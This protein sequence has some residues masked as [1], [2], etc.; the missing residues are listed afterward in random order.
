MYVLSNQFESEIEDLKAENTDNKNI[1]VFSTNDDVLY[2]MDEG[3]KG[4]IN[5]RSQ[6][7]CG[8]S[9]AKGNK[10]ESFVPEPFYDDYRQDNK[11]VYQ[12]VG[13]YFSLQAKTKMQY[14]NL[15]GLWVD[16]G[17]T[18][19]QKIQYYVKYE[20]KCKGVTERSGTKE[21]D[22]NSNELNYRPYE[23]TT[24]L[25]KYRYEAAF[26]GAGYWSRN[27]VIFDGF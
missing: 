11:V 5:G 9:N 15:L 2:L 18:C 10:D 24:G 7:F 4:T 26:Y 19:C 1:L 22:G 25:H 16:A 23:S 8:E 6:L 27:Y 3:S 20:P 21:D 12:S 13:I 17:I 14:K